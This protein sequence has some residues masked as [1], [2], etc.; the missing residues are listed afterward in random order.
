MMLFRPLLLTWILE[1]LN[2]SSNIRVGLFFVFVF[3]FESHKSLNLGLG[4]KS[5]ATVRTYGGSVGLNR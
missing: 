3:F 2:N 4:V 1:K 5:N